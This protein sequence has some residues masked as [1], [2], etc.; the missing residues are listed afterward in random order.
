MQVAAPTGK[1]PMEGAMDA[2]FASPDNAAALK[3]HGVQQVGFGQGRG[4]SAVQ[5]PKVA[6]K[7]RRFRAGVEGL[8]S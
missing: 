1:T 2:G 6:P 7:V 5:K 8:S 3:E 4:R